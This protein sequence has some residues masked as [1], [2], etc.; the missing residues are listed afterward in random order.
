MTIDQ[1]HFFGARGH[2]LQRYGKVCWI[3]IPNA[4]QIRTETERVGENCFIWKYHKS[5]R[6][7]ERSLQITIMF[8][9][10][11]FQRDQRMERSVFDFVKQKCLLGGTIKMINNSEFQEWRLRSV[12]AMHD[13]QFRLFG[14][15]LITNW[16]DIPQNWKSVYYPLIL[17][18]FL[19]FFC[20]FALFLLLQCFPST[21]HVCGCLWCFFHWR[22]RTKCQRV[23]ENEMKHFN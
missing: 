7:D 13:I 5:V 17:N 4:L 9:H 23:R 3:R 19:F 18:E 1:K 12:Y 21:L 22:Q 16:N 14:F 8:C 2:R 11:K 10:W 20:A 15:A 6:Y